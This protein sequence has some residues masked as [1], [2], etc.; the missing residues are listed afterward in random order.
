MSNSGAVAIGGAW[1]RAALDPQKD[2][3]E[4]D[5]PGLFLWMG[6]R[7]QNTTS[8]RSAH[9]TTPT[10]TDPS[11]TFAS[12]ICHTASKIVAKSISGLWMG[13]WS[14]SA[15][16]VKSPCTYYASPG[17]GMEQGTGC[18][19]DLHQVRLTSHEIPP[20]LHSGKS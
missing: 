15:P 1:I 18:G 16:R 13:D 19:G 4:Q 12:Q 9:A 2:C 6:V 7:Y 14:V 11:M 20:G 10:Q 5:I 3:R 8:T 17:S